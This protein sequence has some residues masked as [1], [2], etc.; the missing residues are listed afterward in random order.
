ML[1]VVSPA[2]TLDY[3][4]V[5]PSNLP[6]T[7]PDYLAESEQLVTI[8]RDKSPQELAQMMSISDKLAALNVARFAQWQRPYSM[9]AARPAIFAFKGDVYTGLAVENF[10][11]DDL[12][13]AQQHFR[14]LSGLYGLL[15]PLDL[16]LPYR[17]EMGTDLANARGRNLY[18]FWG[19][20]LT[21]ALNEA[22][23]AQSDDVLVN[24]ASNEYFKAV[25]LK[26]LEARLVT[27]QFK[28][29]KNG[30]FKLVSFFAKK[31]RGQMAAWLIRERIT[32][33]DDICQFDLDGYVFNGALSRD[34]E[35]VFTRKG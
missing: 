1:S 22:L 14:I 15:R 30:Q 7:L 4:S 18:D 17:L 35:L 25:N 2:K 20:R 23:R 24:L 26:R 6:T 12:N 3:D 33:V 10:S 32:R 31:A 27:P 19:D 16:M 11:L 13:Y 5:M 21:I 9:P 28:E 34:N 29:E 8:L